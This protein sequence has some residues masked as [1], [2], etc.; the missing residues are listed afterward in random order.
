MNIKRL[1]VPSLLALGLAAGLTACKSKTSDP[2]M[3]SHKAIKPELG[4]FGIELKN[5]DKSIKPGD[6]FFKYVNGKWLDNTEIPADKSRYGGFSLLGDRSTERVKSIIQDMGKEKHKAGSVE[7]KIGDLYGAFMDEDTINANGLKPIQADLAA[8]RA[9]KDHSAVSAMIGDP[10]MNVSSPVGGWVDIDPK[11]IDHYI[12]FMT[13]S[14]L[15]LP[16]RSYYL[17]DA[18]KSKALRVK[19]LTFLAQMLTFAGEDHPD[20][21]AKAILDFETKM[22]EVHWKP[23]ERRDRDKTYNKMTPAEIRAYAPGFDWAAMAKTAGIGGE[24]NFIVREKSALKEL[25]KIFAGTSMDVLKDYMIAHY[26]SSK[27]GYLPKEIDDVN[28]SF[29]GTALRG[30]T[31]QRPRWKRGVGVVNSTL[32]EAIGQVYVKLYFKPEAKAQMDDLVENLRGAFKDGINNLEW[33]SNKTKSQAQ[34][35]LGK[36]YPKIG[37][38]KNWKNYSTL[39]VDKNDLIGTTK[40]ADVWQWNDMIDDLGKPI[41]REEWGMF[42]QTVNAYYNPSL[43]EIVF[44]AAILQAPFFD[45]AADPAVNYGGI[46]AVI[47]HEMGHGFDDQGA[48]SDGDGVQR[49]WWTSE[50]EAIFKKRTQAL[51]Q[52][53]DSYEP[54][55]GLH[56]KG[57]LTL[58]EN[59]GDLTGLTMAYKA[60]KKSLNGREAPIIDGLTGDQRFFLSFAQIWRNKSRD[61]ALRNQVTTDPHSPGEYRAN[62]PVRNFDAWYKAFNVQPGDALYLPPEKRVTIW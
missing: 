49:N 8:I 58:G 44:P 60:Y 59:I 48:K 50:D 4:T 56:V 22:A 7:Q 45:P 61:E 62:G 30:T 55:P 57:Q 26:I 10:S 16:S 5:M 52:Q 1:L 28:F 23:E 18:D 27:A 2:K 51:I 14:G 29:Y 12:F 21:R 46:G 36:F 31:E 3:A 9:L 11:D 35:K 42:P 24:K 17:K 39:K 54:L 37:Y 20:T 33:M 38:P 19:Y 6:N 43:N 40:S 47:G 41:D 15:G 53:Y 34:Y 13:Q 32:G 25:A